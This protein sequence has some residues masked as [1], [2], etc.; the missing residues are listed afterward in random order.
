MAGEW[1]VIVSFLDNRLKFDNKSLSCLLEKCSEEF[2]VISVVG[3]VRKSELMSCIVNHVSLIP[4]GAVVALWSEPVTVMYRGQPMSL[5]FMDTSAMDEPTQQ[6]EDI[7]RFVLGFTCALSSRL[8][9]CVHRQVTS[10]D[11]LLMFKSCFIFGAEV[12]RLNRPLLLVTDWSASLLEKE[13]Y[14]KRLTDSLVHGYGMNGRKLLQLFGGNSIDVTLLP[15]PNELTLNGGF[16]E[17]VKSVI[18]SVL[19]S[20]DLTIF[21][22]NCYLD[23]C[24]KVVESFTIA[25]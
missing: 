22:R 10:K 12:V 17:C 15:S 20:D 1:K 14:A 2:V 5:L 25:L 4:S 23:Q 18:S 7:D 3:N 13:K 19:E 21:R 16:K 6:Y 24:K 11:W 8:L 9:Y